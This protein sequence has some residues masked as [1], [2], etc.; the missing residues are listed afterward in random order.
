MLDFKQGRKSK[1]KPFKRRQKRAQAHPAPRLLAEFH[2]PAA[3]RRRRWLPPTIAF[4]SN[5]PSLLLKLV[6]A[7]ALAWLAVGVGIE[8]LAIWRSPLSTVD[9]RGNRTLSATEVVHAAGLRAG[10][11]MNGIDPF[12]VAVR[13]S[14]LPRV[15]GVRVRRSLPGTLSIVLQERSAFALIVAEGKPRGIVDVTGTL[16]TVGPSSMNPGAEPLPRIRWSGTLPRAGRRIN[17]PR[18]QSALELLAAAPDFGAAGG[19]LP[20]IEADD[21]S[22]LALHL[23]WQRRTFIF[24]GEG[25]HEALATYRAV[26]AEYGDLFP[27]GGTIDLRLLEPKHGRRIIHHR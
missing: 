11:R 1:G 4:P 22:G 2:V 9:L 14:A 19:E 23:P 3:R 18:F 27:A 20:S 24:P 15:E 8:G 5:F 17:E 6:F 12:A 7:G 25:F 16:L 21:P 26:A 10:L 13:I